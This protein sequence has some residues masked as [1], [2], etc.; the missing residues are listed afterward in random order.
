M[1]AL[2]PGRSPACVRRST[3]VKSKLAPLLLFALTAC[4]SAQTAGPVIAEGQASFY[5]DSLAGNKTANGETYDPGEDT[6]AHRKL[7]F[8]TVLEVERVDTGKK[9]KCRVNDRGPYHDKRIIDL[10]R[11]VAEELE[12][13]GVAKVRLR[14]L[15]EPEKKKK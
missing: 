6:C 9:A 12:I 5:A 11:A 4:P 8:G 14:K 3:T 15:S 10:S 13:E 7:A 1:I 2:S